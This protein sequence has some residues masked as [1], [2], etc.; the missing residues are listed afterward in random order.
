MRIFVIYFEEIELGDI[1]P[2]GDRFGDDL[3]G[4]DP[5]FDEGEE[6]RFAAS[7]VAFHRIYGFPHLI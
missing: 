2:V 6:G 1:L 5:L 7:D 3:D 4:R